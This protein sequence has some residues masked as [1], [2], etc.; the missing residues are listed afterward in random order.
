MK[1]GLDLLHTRNDPGGAAVQ[2]RRALALNPTH[3]GATFQLAMTL[4]RSGQPD[5][6]RQYWEKM[7]PLAEAARDETTAATVRKRLGT[8]APMSEEGIQQALMKAGLDALFV[9]K[10]PN[11][12]AVEFRKVLERNPTHYGATYQLAS[13]LDR[14][15]KPA[16]ARP[17]W[18]KVAKMAEGY[19][20]QNTLDIARARL[21]QKP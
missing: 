1:S 17:L 9:R 19:Q 14:A 3:Y 2:F 21:A 20:D 12:A 15:G 11:A 8:P 6:A 7:L 18:E 5:E 4:D 16:E 10:D 13:A